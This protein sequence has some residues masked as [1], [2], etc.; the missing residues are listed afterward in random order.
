[1]TMNEELQRVT[2]ARECGWNDVELRLVCEGT[3]MDHHVWSSG[4]IGLGGREIPDYLGNLNACVEFEIIIAENGK[5]N[6][7]LCKLSE[8]VTGQICWK[9]SEADHWA[10]ATATAEQRSEAFLRTMELYVES[11]PKSDPEGK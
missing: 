10:C 6:R 5:A 2:I 1:M 7:F 8:V 9:V 4:I 11:D 3:G